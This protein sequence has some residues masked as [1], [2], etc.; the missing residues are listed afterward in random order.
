[1][2]TFT[3]VLPISLA[4]LLTGCVQNPSKSPLVPVEIVKP[5]VGQSAT[6]YMGDPIIK[7]ATGI[8]TDVI[9]LGAGSGA[10]SSIEAGTYCND[11]G[12]VYRNYQ[13]SQA[14]ALKNLY[15]QIGGYVDYV[16]YNAAKNEV[17]PPNGTTYTASEIS[18][19]RVPDGLCRV[20]NSLV[21]TIE[22]NGN[23]SGV[24]KF[25]YREFS[26]DMA[27][28]AFTTDFSVDSKGSDTVTYKGAKF[29]VSKA[30]NSSIS[31]TVISGFDQQNSF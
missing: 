15:G 21:K 31:Y 4:V 27:R 14:V 9:E 8:K 23:A 18:I 20:S 29:K 6:A 16:R 26:N 10:L 24:M 13:N 25:T 1:M 30:D 5:A 11:G 28:A 12:G 22:Y 17:S 19:K 3:V 7:S 2:K